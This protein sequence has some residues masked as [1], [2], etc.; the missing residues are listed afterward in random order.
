MTYKT[1]TAVLNEPRKFEIREITLPPLRPRQVLVQVQACAICTWEMRFYQGAA[2]ESYPFRG[3]HEVSGVVVDKGENAVCAVD[4]GDRVAV[5][6]LTRCGSCY[7]CRR[8][9]DNFC[10]N[11]SGVYLP[12]Q[13]WGPGG[14]SDYIIAED[15]QVYKAAPE[16]DFAELTLSEPIACIV[17]SVNTPPLE[18][19]DT[20]MVQGVG[21]MGLIHLL[22]L[23]QKGVR[24]IVA[25]P[26]AARCEQALACGAD[27]ICDPLDEKFTERVRDFTNG[28]GVKAVFFTAGGAAAI[29]QAIPLLDKRGWLCLYGSVHP[30]GPI[31]VDPNLIHYEELFITGTAKH[32]KESFWQAVEILSNRLIDVSPLISERVSFSELERGFE[33]AL[34]VNTYRVVITFSAD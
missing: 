25:E 32:T 18:F 12:G 15:Y 16:C 1:R 17:R 27:L 11:D 21:V 19:G 9:M 13:P 4:V 2:P 6:I 10:E 3:G 22:L 24:V 5:A 7:Y 29:H 20:A 31:E 14:L 26:N 30:K 23:K 28:R 34:S 33:R 8:G